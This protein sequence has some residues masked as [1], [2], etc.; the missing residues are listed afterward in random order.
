MTDDNL[1]NEEDYEKEISWCLY[2]IEREKRKKAA[3]YDDLQD[4]YEEIDEY[5]S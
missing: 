3:E 1:E 2:E 4:I 5:K